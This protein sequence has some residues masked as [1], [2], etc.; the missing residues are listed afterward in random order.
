MLPGVGTGSKSVHSSR[1]ESRESPPV[2]PMIFKT[3]NGSH[4]FSVRPQGWGA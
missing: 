2:S 1:V 3:A 4:L